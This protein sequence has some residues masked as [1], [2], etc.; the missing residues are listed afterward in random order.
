M[1]TDLCNLAGG[2]DTFTGREVLLESDRCV[3]AIG[4]FGPGTKR[5]E[6]ARSESKR[7]TG[8]INMRHSQSYE[9][10][11]SE[12]FLPI[13][14]LRHGR[15]VRSLRGDTLGRNVGREREPFSIDELDIHGLFQRRGRGRGE[16]DGGDAAVT[17]FLP[18]ARRRGARSRA[19]RRR[20]R[21]RRDEQERGLGG[22]RGGSGIPLDAGLDHEVDRVAVLHAVLFQQFGVRQRFALEQ[23]PLRVG[24]GRARLGGNVALDGGYGIGRGDGYRGREGRFEGLERDLESARR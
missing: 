9:P 11:K 18:R 22:G 3:P 8:S 21:R 24:R 2:Q 1:V 15:A 14:W 16:D 23:E 10:E 7:S 5:K 19:K 20:L 13:L 6:G 4:E 12:Q 17:S